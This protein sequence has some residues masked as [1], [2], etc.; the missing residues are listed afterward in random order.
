[1]QQEK[2]TN[3]LTQN[4]MQG[5]TSTLTQNTMQ[6]SNNTNNVSQNMVQNNVT[7]NENAI[8]DLN[9]N[10]EYNQYT[11]MMLNGKKIVVKLKNIYSSNKTTNNEIEYKLQVAIN[12]E[13]YDTF[14]QT[15][16]IKSEDGKEI[17]YVYI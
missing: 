7:N 5:S 17:H 10:N 2:I 11:E 9:N 13:A 14:P 1:M 12:D 6:S 15:K 3:T 16:V 8:I 4:E